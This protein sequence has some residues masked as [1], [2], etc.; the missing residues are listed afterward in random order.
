MIKN[1]PISQL[2]RYIKD[3]GIDKEVA[4]QIGLCTEAW[5]LHGEVRTGWDESTNPTYLSHGGNHKELPRAAMSGLT[6]D[7]MVEQAVGLQ[8][9]KR[10]ALF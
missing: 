9:V 2:K 1:G 8:D 6:S 7:R 10:P 3:S 4:E 5:L